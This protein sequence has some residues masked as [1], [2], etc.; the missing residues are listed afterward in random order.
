VH[1][2]STRNLRNI[3][4]LRGIR[5]LDVTTIQ[6]RAQDTRLFVWKTNRRGCHSNPMASGDQIDDPTASELS[7]PDAMEP[8]NAET[9]HVLENAKPPPGKAGVCGRMA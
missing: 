3:T 2:I 8:Y 5:S 7:R 1:V 9:S 6:R 4:N